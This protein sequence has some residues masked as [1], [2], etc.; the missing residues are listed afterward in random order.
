MNTYHKQAQDFLKATNT[1]IE[2]KKSAIQ[3]PANWKPHGI[4]YQVKLQNAKHT[5]VFDFWDS[6]HNMQK[7][8]KPNAYDILAT[9]WAYEL[10]NNIDDFASEFGYE[11]PSEAIRVY[12]SVKNEYAELQKL[13]TPDELQQLQDIK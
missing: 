6:Y 10:A 2:I 12:E 1:T 7:N 4:H 8:K 13:F 9:L 3:K 5:Y 11:K